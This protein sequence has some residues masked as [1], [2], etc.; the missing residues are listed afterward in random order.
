MT[1]SGG[2]S[3]RG[4]ISTS[5]SG[6]GELMTDRRP[7]SRAVTEVRSNDT[8]SI[9][10]AGRLDDVAVTDGTPSG[11]IINPESWPA[12]TRVT[13]TSPVALLT[14]TSAIQADHAAP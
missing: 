7:A 12:T 1:P 4:S 14:A 10:A 8:S 3:C 9:S 11:L 2:W 13:L 5:I 6:R